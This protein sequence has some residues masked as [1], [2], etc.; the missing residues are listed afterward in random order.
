MFSET[1][2]KEA[3]GVAIN[4]GYSIEMFKQ[5]GPKKILFKIN[6]T[7]SIL[8]NSLNQQNNQYSKDKN[9]IIL[10]GHSRLV[11]NGSQTDNNNNQPIFIPGMIGVHNGI[12]TNELEIL[13]SHKDI[14]KESQLDSEI[15]LKLFS[16]NNNNF[17][18]INN[19]I[20]KTFDEIEGTASVAIM[21]QSGNELFL[22]NNNGSLFYVEN[23]DSSLFIFASE[24]YI[25]KKLIKSKSLNLKINDSNIKLKP[26]EY[27]I[28]KQKK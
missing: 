21:S 3:A 15:F 19:A 25:L 24:R 13:N 17:K 4:N 8:E 9:P 16:K 27:L 7:L 28:K 20:S 14:K 6:N 2:G 1:R 22:A 10:I 12:I 18:E 23:E 26:D 11:T 5:G